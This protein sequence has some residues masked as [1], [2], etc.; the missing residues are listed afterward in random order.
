[1]THSVLVDT[2]RALFGRLYRELGRGRP[3]G[4]ALENDDDQ[5][6]RGVSAWAIQYRMRSGSAMYSCATANASSLS[7]C[8]SG[9]CR[10]FSGFAICS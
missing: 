9:T 5:G 7:S 2:T 4:T 3:L 6:R 8:V 1:M 10:S